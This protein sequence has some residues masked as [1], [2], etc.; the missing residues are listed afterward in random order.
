LFKYPRSAGGAEQA[1]GHVATTSVGFLPAH[2]RELPH[3][4]AARKK[5]QIARFGI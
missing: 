2:Q 3:Y 5:T 4:G 1:L